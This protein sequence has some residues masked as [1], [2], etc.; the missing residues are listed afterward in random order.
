MPLYIPSEEET[1]GM[2]P[3]TTL[4]IAGGM[5]LNVD[6]LDIGTIKGLILTV[7]RCLDPAKLDQQQVLLQEAIDLY[8]NLG[9]DPTAVPPENEEPLLYIGPIVSYYAANLP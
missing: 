4:G 1:K 3:P 9:L 8:E 2:D 6:G 5:L 7:R